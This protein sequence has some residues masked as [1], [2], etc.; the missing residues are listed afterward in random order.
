M[1][2]WD[3]VLQHMERRVNPHSFATWFRPTSYIG[4]EGRDLLVRN[5]KKLTAKTRHHAEIIEGDTF[6]LPGL[7]QALAGV[8]TGAIA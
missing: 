1:T 6:H 7:R 3:K 8:D 2:A 4:V 5:A